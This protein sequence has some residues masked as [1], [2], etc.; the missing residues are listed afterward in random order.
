VVEP[1][2]ARVLEADAT[3]AD[4]RRVLDAEGPWTLVANLPYNVA[5]AIVLDV[6]D[7]APEVHELLVMV[8]KE[9]GERLA[10]VPGTKAYG[11]PSLRVAYWADAEVVGA[12][13][14]TIFHPKPKVDSALVR[15]RRLPEPAVAADPTVLFRLVRAGFGQRRKML[16]R[17]LA[18]RV[19]V[20]QLEAAG[21]RPTA[22][23]EELEL[24]DWQRLSEVGGEGA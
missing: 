12:V 23:A 9:V 7:R 14:K 20:A 11:I 1:D 17:S 2:G 15:L 8:Q 21:I 16:R 5:T 13:P 19:T 4:W 24:P 3:T 6:L 22:R 10:A 18:D